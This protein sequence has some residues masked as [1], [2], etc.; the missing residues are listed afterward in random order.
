MVSLIVR[1]DDSRLTGSK[2]D[3]ATSPF[4]IAIKDAGIAG[5]DSV[6]NAVI[7]ISV[8]SVANSSFFGSSR[9]LAALAEQKQ[10]PSILGYVDRKGRPIVAVAIAAAV[11]LLAY[12]GTG[13]P[14][15]TTLKWLTAIS[16]LSSN[17]TWAR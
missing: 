15:D 7:L 2:D 6:M 4:V 1:S 11:G 10:A 17:F 16:G 3:P 9:V 12:M 13:L 14:S 5:L 8:L